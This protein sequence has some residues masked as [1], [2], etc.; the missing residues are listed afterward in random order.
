MKVHKCIYDGLGRI[1]KVTAAEFIET[2]DKLDEPVNV[3]DFLPPASAGVLHMG[4][5]DALKIISLTHKNREYIPDIYYPCSVE[6]YMLIS[7]KNAVTDWHQDFS[8]T[9]VFYLVLSGVKEFVVVEPTAANQEIFKEWKESDSLV[10][11]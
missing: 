4:Q 9:S 11:T 10:F 2:L 6:N 8:G 3:I 7:Q 1:T 5:P